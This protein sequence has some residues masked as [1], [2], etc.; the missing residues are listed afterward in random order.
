MQSIFVRKKSAATIDGGISVTVL[1]TCTFT[2]LCANNTQIERQT[3]ESGSTHALR[4]KPPPRRARGPSG[5]YIFTKVTHSR[6]SHSGNHTSSATLF[7]RGLLHSV[8]SVRLTHSAFFTCT[9]RE[10]P[11]SRALIMRFIAFIL[12]L[13][14]GSSLFSSG[15]LSLYWLSHFTLTFMLVV[16]GFL[17]SSLFSSSSLH[18]FYRLLLHKLTKPWNKEISRKPKDKKCVL[19]SFFTNCSS[20]SICEKSP[21]NEWGERRERMS[22]KQAAVGGYWVEN[23][24]IVKWFFLWLLFLLVFFFNSPSVLS[25][26]MLIRSSLRKMGRKRK[27]DQD[28]WFFRFSFCVEKRLRIFRRFSH[29]VLTVLLFD[30]VSREKIFANVNCRFFLAF[31]CGKKGFYGTQIKKKYKT[32]RLIRVYYQR[33]VV[34][35][36]WEIALGKNASIIRVK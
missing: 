2:S 21:V 8:S 6:R 27:F 12:L 26:A 16:C 10:E 31:F 13:L 14:Y 23:F 36:G 15:S 22:S 24:F 19:P 7:F 25:S 35:R 18:T 17:F 4:V 1:W 9:F 28:G 30:R 32:A 5:H 11:V 34:A 33:N 20:S 3:H 29:K